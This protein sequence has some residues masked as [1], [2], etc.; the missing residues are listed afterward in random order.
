[1]MF[2]LQ[3]AST[4]E[5]SPVNSDDDNDGNCSVSCDESDSVSDGSNDLII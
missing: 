3:M 1:M 2:A 4:E 5:F